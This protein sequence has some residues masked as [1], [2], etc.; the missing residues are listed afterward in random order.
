MWC[1]DEN[2]SV[3]VIAGGFVHRDQDDF[4]RETR[5]ADRSSVKA[6]VRRRN[7][8]PLSLKCLTGDISPASACKRSAHPCSAHQCRAMAQNRFGLRT[9]LVLAAAQI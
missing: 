6:P 9:W 7:G 5:L 3:D 4:D 8:A 2:L 1:C